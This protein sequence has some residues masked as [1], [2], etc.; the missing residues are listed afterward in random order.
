MGVAGLWLGYTIASVF[1]DI[2]FWVIINCCDWNEIANNLQ[3][4]ME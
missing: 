3:R 2:G 4:Q 1:L